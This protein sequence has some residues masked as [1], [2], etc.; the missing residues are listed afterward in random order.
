MADTPKRYAVILIGIIEM[1]IGVTTIR[2]SCVVDVV[3]LVVE[4]AVVHER[5]GGTITFPKCE[6]VRQ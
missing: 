3:C 6:L 2:K 1:I 5:H 4:G